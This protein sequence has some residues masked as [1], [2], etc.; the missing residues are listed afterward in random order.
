MRGLLSLMFL[1][2]SLAAAPPRDPA[3]LF[4]PT[5]V[6][7]AELRDPAAL[8]DTIAAIVKGTPLEDGLKL[9]HDRKDANKDARLFHGAPGL[10]S[11]AV[12]ASPEF[13]AE[14][15]K[16]HGA[17]V[18]FT[19][20]T[21]K[22]EPK[23]AACAL[24]GES[25]AA[26]LLVKMHLANES[27]F[28]RVGAIDGVPIY[29]SRTV[30]T[31]AYDPNTGKPIPHEPKPATEGPCEP[32]FA[33]LPGL[34]VVGSNRE[35]IADLLPRYAGKATDSLATSDDFKAHATD[36]RPGLGAFVRLAE[37]V[38]VCDAAKKA[39]KDVVD[40]AH[41]AYLKLVVNPKAVPI[42]TARLELKA[43]GFVLAVSAHR[44]AAQASALL[45]L[46]DGAVPDGALKICPSNAAGTIALAMPPK[47]RRAA[48]IVA[49]ADSIAKADGE[50]GQL[51]GEW[52]TDAERASGLPVR[53]RFLPDIRAVSLVFAPKAELPPRVEPRPLLALH[54][55]PEAKPAEWETAIPKWIAVIAERKSP[56]QP[57]SETILGVKVWTLPR[58]GGAV[59]F[60]RS[61]STWIFGLDRKHVAACAAA[62]K[63][64]PPFGELANRPDSTPAAFA[65][66][67]PKGLVQYETVQRLL[68]RAA[69]P[70]SNAFES[71]LFGGG[72]LA[73]PGLFL[74][75]LD[76]SSNAQLTPKEL[77]SLV[78]DLPSVLARAVN[79]S[80]R[81]EVEARWDF[82][83]HGSKGFVAN[84]IPLLERFGGDGHPH[85][86]G[87]PFDR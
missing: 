16:F 53:A 18:G 40:A 15:R 37:F 79:R 61:E 3:A 80:N 65:A 10:S 70:N 54:L 45:D 62:A 73:P 67:R 81:I 68:N 71:G 1:I 7:Y 57:S 24:L 32:T 4:P 77:E 76:P 31:V 12:L 29:Q 36:R 27:T 84:L 34:F 41:L 78:G 6:A 56:V 50:A 43:D 14:V 22:N 63:E 55:E 64:K 75:G 26:A 85:A 28:R 48:A 30:P 60:A 20:L 39:K 49:L 9:L 86:R 82:G 19:G 69:T 83:P 17:A 66:V 72:F 74:P 8:A 21:A 87:F 46:L 38:K 47:P 42:L 44:E 52:L 51:P 11:A 25:A 23:I 13:L 5:T 58:A 33:Y 35:A 59:H 2:P